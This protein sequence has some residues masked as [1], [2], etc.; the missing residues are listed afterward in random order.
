MNT[1]A[2]LLI[3]TPGRI[4][5][6]IQQKKI[7]CSYLYFDSNDMFSSSMRSSLFDITTKL[8]GY[9]KV[10]VTATK[11]LT[12]SDLRFTINEDL[13]GPVFS[14]NISHYRFIYPDG[15]TKLQKLISTLQSL[16]LQFSEE[17]IIVFCETKKAV[18]KLFE[19]LKIS[20]KKDKLYSIHGDLDQNTREK[21][22]LEFANS[23][24]KILIS[25]G[26]LDGINFPHC[27]FVL[28]YDYNPSTL[29]ARSSRCG[30]IYRKGSS[31]YFIVPNDVSDFQERTSSL[32]IQPKEL[33]SDL[34]SLATLF[35]GL[36]L[37]FR[38]SI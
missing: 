9:R 37:F 23:P 12:Y 8:S 21:T 15:D 11:P 36:Y 27:R 5:D 26:T 38:F 34:S 24:G 7:T 35:Y 29:I 33:P 2:D 20:F 32:F 14:P 1:K 6:M 13:T 4:I 28:H 3:G 19:T 31:I 25:T 17:S 18:D 30:N 16:N 22:L 10:I